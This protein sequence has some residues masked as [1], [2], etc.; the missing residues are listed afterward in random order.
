M[1]IPAPW[2]L[3][4]REV[5]GGTFSSLLPVGRTSDRPEASLYTRPSKRT[6]SVAVSATAVDRRSLTE[7][8]LAFTTKGIVGEPGTVS[9]LR[10]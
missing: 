10:R 7:R 2:S 6:M 1:A 4:G 5:T 8:R 3:Y 9:E